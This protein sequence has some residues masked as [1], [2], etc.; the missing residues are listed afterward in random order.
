M[1]LFNYCDLIQHAC[2]EQEESSTEFL[3]SIPFPSWQFINDAS[4]HSVPL[5]PKQRNKI[6]KCLFPSKIF[7]ESNIPKK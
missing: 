6:C 1:Q 4:G 5:P 2:K 3:S 7:P